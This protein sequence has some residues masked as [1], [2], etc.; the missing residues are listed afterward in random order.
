MKEQGDRFSGSRQTSNNALDAVLMVAS[1][2]SA[3]QQ[4]SAH[5]THFF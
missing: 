4:P 1:A 5:G 2:V 3:Q